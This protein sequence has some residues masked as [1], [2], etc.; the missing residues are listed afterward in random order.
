MRK[1]GNLNKMNKSRHEFKYLSTKNQLILLNAR[2]KTIMKV[3]EHTN[4]DS[5]YRIRS[6]YF[7]DW[8]N[9]NFFENEE[10]I[11][12]REKWR[13]R[14]YNEDSRNIS[15][16]CKQK[17]C[18]KVIKTSCKLT[19]EQ[20]DGIMRGDYFVLHQDNKLI[21]RFLL[22]CKIDQLKPKV[23]VGYERKP[24]ICKEGNVR[25]TFDM[26]L[27]SSP[28]IGGFFDRTIRK[29]P[30]FRTATHMVEVKFDEFLQDYVNQTVQM[31]DMRR[32]TFSKYYY[33]RKFNIASARNTHTKKGEG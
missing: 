2:L 29:R 1:E 23:I 4:G 31:A 21:N 14:A 26:N 18:D 15:L 19:I 17:I 22:R 30:I 33:S 28:D 8:K 13:I 9:S 27:Y 7:D 11:S 10:G 16:E 20:Y 25:V 6:I 24:Y 32:M 12:P 3:D 5:T